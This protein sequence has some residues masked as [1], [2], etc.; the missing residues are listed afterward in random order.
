MIIIRCPGGVSTSVYESIQCVHRFMAS[1]RTDGE[2]EEAL[3]RQKAENVE[4]RGQEEQ[5]VSECQR[6]KSLTIH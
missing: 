2:E 5:T 4:T 1:V 6:R 3:V